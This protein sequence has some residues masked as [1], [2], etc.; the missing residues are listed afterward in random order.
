MSEL[1]QGAGQFARAVATLGTAEEHTSLARA[2]SQL[3]EVEEKVE[4]VHQAQSDADFYILSELIHDYVGMVHAVKVPQLTNN[5]L[6]PPSHSF[7]HGLS[8]SR[9]WR[10]TSVP[11]KTLGFSL[12]SRL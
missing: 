6:S 9:L 4:S 11:F 7:V 10:F 12:C 3:S 8:I 5:S 1:A 2:L